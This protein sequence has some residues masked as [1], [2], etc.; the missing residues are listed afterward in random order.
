MQFGMNGFPKKAGNLKGLNTFDAT[1]V[2]K[3][4]LQGKTAYVRGEKIV[5]T[6]PNINTS[7]ATAVAGDISLGASAYI[8]GSKVIGIANLRKMAV[9]Q[10]F[11][12]N[13]Q[14]NVDLIISGLN[15][16]PKVVA[17]SGVALTNPYSFPF[18][19]T[20]A[21]FNDTYNSLTYYAYAT[22]YDTFS[23]TK[24]NWESQTRAA[25]GYSVITINQS[26]YPNGFKFYTTFLAYGGSVKWIAIE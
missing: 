7:D 25:Y 23:T 21:S 2:A 5:G 14:P 20:I 8:N 17:I 10:Y 13:T 19:T 3:N 24:Y 11:F 1:A 18:N 12:N 6:N 22:I 26:L 15:F 4:I 16:S 9:G